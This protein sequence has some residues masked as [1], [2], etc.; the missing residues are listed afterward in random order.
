MTDS[1][2]AVIG[3]GALGTAVATTLMG[4]GHRVGV[5]NRTPAR[6]DDLVARGASR[7]ASPVDAWASELVL[8]CLT[9]YQAATEVLRPLVDE[10]E[11]THE[12]TVVLLT[13][14]TS[15]EAE[16]M[17][18][19]L[20]PCGVRY[21]A[22]GIQTA[23]DDIGSPRASFILSGSVAGFD[24]H[25]STLEL[26]GNLTWLGADARAAAVWNL[27]MFGLWYDAQ[28]GLLRAYEQVAT[29]DVPAAEFASA[30]A[31]QLGHVVQ[32]T[33]A[34]AAEITASSYPR[35]PASL[36]EHLPVLQNLQD[37]RRRFR[38]G[39]GGLADAERLVGELVGTGH[40][41]LGLTA[42]V[43]AELHP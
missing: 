34:T 11:R 9:D 31:Q 2:T 42:I 4:A 18:Q 36:Q 24:E 5:W 22:A 26:L 41:D 39:D 12:K 35:G 32:A 13:T 37:A 6:A 15:A 1:G 29:V 33:A 3:T 43:D 10:A 8:V 14:G 17:H 7:C 23:P 19:L 28:L 40:G 25:R 21:V 30:A 38:L 27:A 16:V 20:T